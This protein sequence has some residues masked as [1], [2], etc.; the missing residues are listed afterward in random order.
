MKGLDEY[1]RNRIM[2]ATPGAL[3]VMLYDGLLTRVQQAR[4]H[5]EGERWNDAGNCLGK[6]HDILFELMACLDHSHAPE[7][8]G[9][10]TALYGYCSTTLIEALA[11]RDDSKLEEVY[12]LLRPLRDAW[13]E[14]EQKLKSGEEQMAVNE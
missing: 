3:I 13:F 8:A 9:N 10:L 11:A 5:F 7:L 2:T 6:A 12:T 14:A 4:K 1:K